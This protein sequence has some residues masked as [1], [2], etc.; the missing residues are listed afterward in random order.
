MNFIEIESQER[1]NDWSMSKLQSHNY[2]ELYFLLSGTRRFFLNDKSFNITAPVA[3]IIPPFCM[4]KTE[5]SAYS[6]ININISPTILTPSEKDFLDSLSKNV[7]FKIDLKKAQPFLTLLKSAS[8]IEGNPLNEELMHSFLHVLLYLLQGDALI[9]L[10]IPAENPKSKSKMNLTITRVIEYINAHYQEDFKLDDLCK[11]FFISKNSLCQQFYNL[12]H[13]SII[14]YRT[15]IRIS[16]AKELLISSKKSLE[17]IA[18]L[19]GFS[20]ANYFSL[21]F[22]KS[23]GLS[24]A[25]YRKSK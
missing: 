15:F 17:Q 11:L 21:I 10:H 2:F 6:R 25:N 19:C 16:K 7:L 22:K 20:S 13:C 3:C 1:T 12:M 24:P 9:P 5:G 23:V 8:A 14:Q 18:E 4:H